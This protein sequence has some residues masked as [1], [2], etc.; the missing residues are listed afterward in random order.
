[1]D[2]VLDK[3]IKLKI[4]EGPNKTVQKVQ[5][6]YYELVCDQ[7]SRKPQLYDLGVFFWQQSKFMTIGKVSNADEIVKDLGLIHI[8]CDY[9]SQSKVQYD[10]IFGFDKGD[11]KLLTRIKVRES[12]DNYAMPKCIFS[13][14][15]AFVEGDGKL[16]VNKT[17]N[18]ITEW[19]EHVELIKVPEMYL[20]VPND[21]YSV[22]GDDDQFDDVANDEFDD[23]TFQELSK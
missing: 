21:M 22:D 5:F 8:L 4:R 3:K 16:N 23:S 13:L 10:K 12:L 19:R 9:L 2:D 18:K 11:K 1:L 20:Q 14:L 15:D 7:L 17:K 6:K